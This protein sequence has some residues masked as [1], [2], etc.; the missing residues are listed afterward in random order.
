MFIIIIIMLV[1]MDKHVGFI[2]ART[3]T[4]SVGLHWGAELEDKGRINQ[5]LTLE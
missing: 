5:S 3:T 2:S 1:F 4:A